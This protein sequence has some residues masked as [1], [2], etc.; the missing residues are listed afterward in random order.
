LD[1]NGNQLIIPGTTINGQIGLNIPPLARR[2][3]Q[4]DG[5]G[6]IKVGSVTGF[7]DGPVNAVIVFG[8]S[9]GLAG[10]PATPTF[11]NEFTV[12]IDSIAGGQVATGLAVMN[13]E[14]RETVLTLTLYSSTGEVITTAEVKIPA[15]GQIALFASQFDWVGSGVD[16][17]NF[18]G[19]IKAS[20]DGRVSAVAIQTRNGIQFATLPVDGN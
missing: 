11:Y 15:M 16:F 18:R 12:P 3:L 20:P 1:R 2:T 14:N 8:G 13:R 17:D 5:N 9:I 7:A 10:V 19:A 6:P 4:T